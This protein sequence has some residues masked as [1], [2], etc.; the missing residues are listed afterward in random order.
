[1]A[2]HHAR[3]HTNVNAWELN[4]QFSP[5][6]RSAFS[7]LAAAVHFSDH[8][9]RDILTIVEK[10]AAGKSTTVHNFFISMPTIASETIG[11]IAK[12]GDQRAAEAWREVS[13]Q[14]A[15]KGGYVVTRE[16]FWEGTIG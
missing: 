14:I 12:T 5:Q 10:W 1:M 13:S 3:K 7:D 11:H 15:E 2:G 9:D 16:R 6:V 4:V 8:F